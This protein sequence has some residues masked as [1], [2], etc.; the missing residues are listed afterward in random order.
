MASYLK[1]K[2]EILL[3]NGI[4]LPFRFC[5]CCI[6]GGGGD[7]RSGRKKYDLCIHTFG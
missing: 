5:L 4:V 6:C 1:T 7:D 3:F 2:K